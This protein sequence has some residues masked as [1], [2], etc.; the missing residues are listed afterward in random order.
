MAAGG[1]T[2]PGSKSLVKIFANIFISF[3]GAGVLGLPYAFK[4]VTYFCLC[5]NDRRMSNTLHG[6][7]DE[8]GGEIVVWILE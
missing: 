6:R 5:F 4:E 1:E 3:I 2:G 7:G 8:G